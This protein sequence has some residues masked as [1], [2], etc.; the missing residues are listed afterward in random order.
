MKKLMISL[1]VASCALFANAQSDAQT[2][3]SLVQIK[4]VENSVQTNKFGDNWWIS[5][6]GGANIFNGVRTNGESPFKHLG[7]VGTLSAG[8]WHT[9]GFGWRVAVEAGQ[10]KPFDAANEQ[11]FMNPHFDAM[12]NVSNLI[13]GYREDRIWNLI[14]YVGAG[15]AGANYEGLDGIHGSITVNYGLLNT[16]RVAKHWAINLD[17]SGK[18]LRNGFSGVP[19]SS[20]HSMMWGAQVGVTYKFNEVGWEQ[21]I[22]TDALINDYNEMLAGLNEDLIAKLRQKDDEIAQ[23]I[24]QKDKEIQD[25]I[26]KSKAANLTLTQSVFFAFNSSSI[27]SKKEILNL[28]AI[29]EAVKA[30]SKLNVT[31][32]G[33]ADEVGNTDYNMALSERR[34]EAVKA[35]LVKMGVP[36]ERII[37]VEGLGESTELN[38]NV[39]LNRRVVVTIEN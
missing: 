31:V 14:P 34:A 23:I 18:F 3:E 37:T 24:K 36:A 13:C 33:Y 17:L 16:F 15:W 12:F 25:V 26:Q 4:T 21:T 7:F 11:F 38:P 32:K 8:K 29:A 5:L 39:Q 9:P 27:E 10:W 6:N 19:G 30:D 2:T 1:A 20:G 28:E 22:D 35:Q